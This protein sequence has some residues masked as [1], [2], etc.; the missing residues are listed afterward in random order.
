MEIALYIDLPDI[1]E[2]LGKEAGDMLRDVTIRMA[3]RMKALHADSNPTGRYYR[4]GS[5]FH[6]A[7]APGEPPAV[8]TGNL[9]GS[10]QAEMN[11]RDLVGEITLNAY[12]WYLEESNNRPWIM[13]SLDQVLKDFR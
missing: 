3:D 8:D 10:I 1:G 4:R 9:L 5:A 6:R 13:P 12:G 2:M 7:S 11:E